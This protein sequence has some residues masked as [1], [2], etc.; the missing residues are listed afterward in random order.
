MLFAHLGRRLLRRGMP[1]MAIAWAGMR[2]STTRAD[3]TLWYNGDFD[4]NDAATNENNVPINVGGNT[5][6]EQSLVFNKF[7]VGAGQ[8]WSISSVFSN[9]QIAYYGTISTATWQIRSGMSSGNG[10]TLVASGD[11]SATVTQ[12]QAADGNNYIEPEFHL[13]ASVASVTLTAG[14]YWVAVAPDSAYTASA[15]DAL[16]YYGSQA[17]EETTSGAKAVGTPKGNDGNSFLFNDL[18]GP[19]NLNYVSSSLDY[20]EGVVGLATPEPTGF[21]PAV[22]LA[23]IAWLASRRRRVRP[24][25]GPTA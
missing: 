19:G 13:T 2:S 7:T 6:V 4:L 1:L 20:S 17:F 3:T 12:T 25:V 21:L 15:S 16:N 23:G 24:A 10:G 9:D 22:G 14:T 18:S 8:K 5:E 11:T